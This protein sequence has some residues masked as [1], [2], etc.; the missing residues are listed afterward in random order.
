MEIRKARDED[1][2]KIEALALKFDL[3]HENMR[4]ENFMVAEEGGKIVGIG[5]IIP[6]EDCLELASVGVRPEYQKSGIGKR[7]VQQLLDSVKGE[8]YLATILPR[9]FEKF[10]FVK[11]DQVP[12]SMLK[13]ES[14]CVGCRKELCTVMVLKKWN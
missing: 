10:G 3:D 2:A 13:K 11:T 9:Y 14:W 4:A 5:S 8:V 6:H 7:L 12:L 1:L